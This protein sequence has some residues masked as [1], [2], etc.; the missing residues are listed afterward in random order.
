M[1]GLILL[2]AELMAKPNF[3]VGVSYGDDKKD[4]LLTL[5]E[6]PEKKEIAP[7]FDKAKSIEILFE[8]KARYDSFVINISRDDFNDRLLKTLVIRT[9]GENVKLEDRAILIRPDLLTQPNIFIGHI[10]DAECLVKDLI[11]DGNSMV[12]GSAITV[13]YVESL[14]IENCMM[15]KARA[16]IYSDYSMRAIIRNCLIEKCGYYEAKG[17]GIYL[18]LSEVEIYNSV[19]QDNEAKE[20]GG[21]LAN[22]SILKI[23]DSTLLNNFAVNGCSICE[24]N[25]SAITIENTVCKRNAKNVSCLVDYNG[26]CFV[27]SA[28]FLN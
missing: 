17:G 14:V 22:E 7:I 18:N 11:I 21:I 2:N 25:K 8:P 23:V 1:F 9:R 28:F 4:L 24:K 6:W 12:I 5:T 10:S 3:T 20:G 15:T 26:P 27:N 13:A 19:I 16:G